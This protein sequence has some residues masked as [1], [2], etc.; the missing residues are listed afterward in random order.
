MKPKTLIIYD[1]QILYEILNEIKEYFNFEIIN[2]NSVD[3]DKIKLSDFSSYLIITPNKHNILN[4]YLTIKDLPL[5]FNKFI[6]Y[7][8]ISFLKSN[9]ANQ[10][11][12]KIGKYTLD[13]NSRKITLSSRILNLTERE[14]SLIIFIFSKKKATIKELQKNVWGYSSNLE[15]HTVETHIYRLRKKMYDVF[16]DD[17]FI[18]NDKN[19]YL[20][21]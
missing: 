3:F 14:V 21:K 2:T 8:N 19:G 20:I 7:I 6:E 11:N 9:F 4:N 15:T 1:Y 12:L 10:S 17:N 5:S 18:R 13:V 16:N